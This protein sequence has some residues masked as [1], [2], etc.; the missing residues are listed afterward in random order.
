MG[1]DLNLAMVTFGAVTFEILGAEKPYGYLGIAL[2]TFYDI[3]EKNGDWSQNGFRIQ[4]A[5]IRRAFEIEKY[6]D[7]EVY[8]I[9]AES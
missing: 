2:G 6:Q 1:P 4:F 5:R 3:F 8:L 7:P 9:L